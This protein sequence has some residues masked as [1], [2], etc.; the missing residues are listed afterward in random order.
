MVKNISIV[1]ASG[2]EQ[3]TAQW[4]KSDQGEII[5]NVSALRAG[6]WFLQVQGSE[7]NLTLKFTIVR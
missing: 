5:C 2:T 1:S 4:S 7:K 3:H 6:L